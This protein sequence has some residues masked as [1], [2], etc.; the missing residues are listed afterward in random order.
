MLH[1]Q[2]FTGSR[3]KQ[4]GVIVIMRSKTVKRGLGIGAGVLSVT[5]AVGAIV[6]T[7]LPAYAEET[8]F[9]IESLIQEVQ[10]RQTPYRV[11]E[12]V[13]DEK[14]SEI[15][16]YIPG[17]EP[18]LST[19]EA[20]TGV[21]SNWVEGLK[22]YRTPQTRKQHME[23]MNAELEQFYALRG[24]GDNKPVTY[25]GYEE[26]SEPKN[27]YTELTFEAETRTGFYKNYTGAEG[28][29]RYDLDFYYAGNCNE[30]LFA[31][32]LSTQYY[33]VE[34][35]VQITYGMM[36]NLADDEEVYRF[37][38]QVG[39]HRF[40]KAGTWAE[41]KELLG[42]ELP[43]IP[44]TAP[45]ATPDTASRGVSGGDAS[46]SD[47]NPSVSDNDYDPNTPI[48]YY[49]ISMKNWQQGETPAYAA[50]YGVR[51][52]TISAEGDYEFEA[53]EGGFE[54]T[55]QREPIY[56]KGGFANNLWFHTEVLN[57]LPENAAYFPMEVITL[58]VSELNAMPGIPAFDMLY[59]NSGLQMLTE[60]ETIAPYAAANDISDG[61]RLELFK[62]VVAT[63]KPCVLDARLIYNTNTAGMIE[64]NAG[65]QDTNIFR[66]AT[67]FIQQSP[68]D[69]YTNTLLTGAAEP[70][71]AELL[72]TVVVD[73]DKNFVVEQTYSVYSPIA[74][75]RPDF[76]A[77]NIYRDGTAVDAMVAEGF[78]A[79]LDEILSENLNRE[80]DSSGA[81]E[82]LPTD[83]SQASAVRHVL[84]Y[85]NRRQIEV[86]KNLRV[87][88]IQPAKSAEN[89]Y[90][91]TE[92]EIKSWAPGVE[93][94]QIVRMTTAE[95]I[96]KIEDINE[97]YDLIYIGTDRDYMNTTD[98]VQ[99]TYGVT[100]P[101]S[102]SGFE[103]G[104][105]GWSFWS[106][107][108]R[109][110][111]GGV[112]GSAH[113]V[114]VN[115][116]TFSQILEVV[117]GETYTISAWGKKDGGDG[118]FGVN[119]LSSTEADNTV[120]VASDVF[121]SDEFERVSIQ[122]TMPADKPRLKV[123]FYGNIIV[124]EVT[125]QRVVSEDNPVSST[126]SVSVGPENGGFENGINSWQDWGNT[127]VV[128][129]GANGTAHALRVG[130]ADGGLAQSFVATAGAQYTLSGFGKVDAGG[131][132]RLGVECRDSAGNL[133]QNVSVA[134]TE[135]DYTQKSLN[136]TPVEGTTQMVLYC[137]Q[138]SNQYAYFDEIKLIKTVS[139]AEADEKYYAGSTVFNDSSMD[140]LIYFHTGDIRYTSM[141]LAGQ[142][143]TEYIDGN[144]A[145]H[146]YYFN[147]VRY[148]GNDISE[149]KKEALLSFLDAS[150][151]IIISDEVFESAATV[152][153]DRD[154]NGYSVNLK[155]GAY[156]MDTLN[157][158]GV[159]NDDVSSLKVSE[160]YR[161]IAYADINF[162]GATR[163][164]TG[165]SNWLGDD[166]ND[167]ITS[168]IVEEIKGQEELRTRKIDTDH[169]DNS[170]YMYD[171]IKEAMAHSNF[172]ARSDMKA[173]SKMFQFYLNRPKVSVANVSANGNLI[174]EGKDNNGD[175][176]D[177]YPSA[178]GK[179]QLEYKFTIENEGAASADTRYKCQLFIDINADGKFSANEELGDVTLTQNGTP[180]SADNLYI[181]RQ[182]TLSR[183][184]PD[185][186]KGVLPWKIQI[187]QVNNANIHNGVT[188]YTKLRGLERETLK[189]LQVCRDPVTSKDWWG[190]TNEVFFNLEEKIANPEDIYHILIYGGEYGGKKYEGIYKDFDI[191]VDFMQISGFEAAYA[192]NPYLLNDYNMLILGFSDAYGNI[193]GNAEEGPVSAIINF[194]EGGKS[195]LFAHDTVSY[196]NYEEYRTY[197]A[198]G[199]GNEL[200]QGVRNRNNVRALSL[201]D[202]YHNSYNLTRYVRG[203]VGMDRYGITEFDVLKSG[204]GLTTASADWATISATNDMAY[205]PKSGRSQTTPLTHGYTYS[206]INAKDINT[207]N[208]RFEVFSAEQTGGTAFTNQYLNLDYGVVHYHDNETDEGEVG[209]NKN[210]EVSN[211][212]V[213]KVNSGQITDYPYELSDSF[214][215]SSTHNQYYQLDFMSNEDEDDLVVW[216]CLGHRTNGNNV[217]QET[218][219]SASP[220]DV[221]NNYYIYN[222]G[223]ITYTGVGHAGN[224]STVDEAKLFINT[225]IASYN[226]G[227]KDPVITT[228]REGSKDA[229]QMTSA[230]S[231]YDAANNLYFD[232][233]ETTDS[234]IAGKQKLYFSVSDPNFV[235]GERKIAVNFFYQSD[236]ADAQEIIYDG[237][238]VKVKQ[239]PVEVYN[240]T[241]NQRVNDLSNL[242]SGGVY[243]VLFD[244]S[245]MGEYKSKFSVYFEA[246][247][248]ITTYKSTVQ[249]GKSY[250]KFDYTRVELFDLQ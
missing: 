35:A 78:E 145:N 92:E 71:T 153:E 210:G 226:A 7:I 17:H 132:G 83:V 45:E 197:K 138:D 236:D 231:Y 104:R 196:F 106:D 165:D 191:D 36:E 214:M 32:A 216:Y 115:G 179:Y 96:G 199:S 22:E 193:S 169:I 42:E 62:H 212:W 97:E 55:I 4:K 105:T 230:Y 215:V 87:L 43:E 151:P 21:W 26:S 60:S 143:D 73:A 100:V 29:E 84:N 221:S 239:M 146:V 133:L 159:A 243:Y 88:E 123:Y 77:D 10:S 208:G 162:S 98:N 142:L 28:V 188:G 111:E 131:D 1:L 120:S 80:A 195:V 129:G 127:E 201:T 130:V 247:S 122:Y 181:G 223:N 108:I 211:L 152:Y 189:I 141:E 64:I 85:K 184:V 174:S 218:I 8:L 219:Y 90:D 233:A 46:V 75:V 171:F 2:R 37:I 93:T 53:V 72:N 154:Y 74:L 59:L 187:S 89:S 119:V 209:G 185:G 126:V 222:K 125:V 27:G 114:D 213:T 40:E 134:F 30:D 177:I 54:S 13:P 244:E 52:I 135:T 160:G 68:T 238:P 128:E 246:Q 168:I 31:G 99:K 200:R 86:K 24:F 137:W 182:Y 66:L 250:S 81:Y 112:N 164:F 41:V 228:L 150:Y 14:A 163:E 117:P 204:V 51:G 172:Y 79:V 67:M 50:L 136:F 11:L 242:A 198:D 39:S 56:Y 157:A 5:I 207:S 107:A 240:A 149:S 234:G 58:T 202:Q 166:W 148:G 57:M 102:N 15:G 144:R 3:Q 156:N 147:P 158:M 121:R 113:A 176:Y 167:E 118:G 178:N 6:S 25:L 70:S 91:L 48:N 235:K 194:I 139:A 205:V 47:N 241:N 175:V 33:Y 12:I 245:V 116:G 248:T 224:T 109:I 217:K 155:P 170:S 94:V 101:V 206:I 19:R 95:F 225:M 16:Y 49:L 161:V 82:L 203:L 173:D 34:G 65:L 124:D 23:D 140:G 180:V 232:S 9:G 103:E 192:E 18:I 110:V 183:N 63:G 186:Y 61:M 227:I 69:Y 237:T 76:A 249:T 44:G 220:N 229:E 20:G 38:D 190:G